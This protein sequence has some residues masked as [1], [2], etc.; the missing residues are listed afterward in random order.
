MFFMQGSPSR[1]C[2]KLSLIAG[3]LLHRIRYQS[4]MPI[5]LLVAVVFDLIITFGPPAPHLSRTVWCYARRLD[6]V[7]FAVR[8]NNTHFK[9]YL[10]E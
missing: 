1:V 4:H 2:Q 7:T 8:Y 9:I 10:N 5:L 3:Q 6:L